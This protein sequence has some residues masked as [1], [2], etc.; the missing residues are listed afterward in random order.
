MKI[1]NNQKLT[2]EK[3]PYKRRPDQ[4]CNETRF[5]ISYFKMA[6]AIKK[7]FSNLEV[8]SVLPSEEFPYLL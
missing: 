5:I 2:K 3:P 6:L 8:S 7:T 4:Q 1:R